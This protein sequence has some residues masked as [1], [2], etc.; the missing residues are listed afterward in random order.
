LE[1]KA[2]LILINNAKLG[3]FVNC[4]FQQTQKVFKL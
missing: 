4:P 2:I 1:I 3:W